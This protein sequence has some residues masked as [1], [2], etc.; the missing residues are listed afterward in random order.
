[1]KCNAL[2][3]VAWIH[4]TAGQK[5][6]KEALLEAHNISG[7]D[8][9]R[10]A[11]EVSAQLRTLAAV[12]AVVLQ[13]MEWRRFRPRKGFD[14]D[15]VEEALGRLRISANL[16]DAEKP[17]MQQ[18]CEDISDGHK[19]TIGLDVAKYP[20]KKLSPAIPADRAESYWNLAVS[21]AEALKFED[22]ALALAVCHHF[23]PAGNGKFKGRKHEMGSP[24]LRFPGKDFTTTEC[25]WY[26]ASLAETLALAV[27]KNWV[28]DGGLPAWAD[29]TCEFS[30]NPYSSAKALWSATWS[31]N[32][33]ACLWKNG[34]LIAAVVGGV[35]PQW[36]VPAMGSTKETRKT[37]WATRNQADPFYLYMPTKDG[38]EIKAQR[39]DIGR[40]ATALAVEWNAEQKGQ[41][42]RQRAS[43]HVLS[44]AIADARILFLRHYIGGTSTSPSIRASQCLMGDSDTWAP[45]QDCAA[46]AKEFADKL[47]E[48]HYLVTRVFNESPNKYQFNLPTLVSRKGDASTAYWRNMTSIFLEAMHRLNNDGILLTDNL[49]RT[50]HSRALLAFDSVAM[51]GA[52]T[53]DHQLMSARAQLERNINWSLKKMCEFLKEY[54]DE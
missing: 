26:G 12:A 13:H 9:D 29:R 46:E 6:V 32:A 39:L 5:T 14:E 54:A 44:P 20:P 41:A 21:Y 53:S 52:S 11:F 19:P 31:S 18:A 24:A 25:I 23:F 37:W 4:T 50:I 16:I 34:A 27:P 40:D 45:S 8:L 30:A 48:I 49:L 2:E 22:A 35:P 15:A 42:M 7:L 47:I 28:A 36:I 43:E 3:D 1:M 51:S 17:F 10:P 38:K 33:P